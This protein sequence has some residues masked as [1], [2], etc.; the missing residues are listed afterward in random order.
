MLEAGHRSKTQPAPPRII[1]EAL[2]NPDRDPT[3]PWL[4]LLDG[5]QR[6]Q[7]LEAV[8]PGLVVWSSLWTKWPDARIRFD[9]APDSGAGTKLAWTLLVTEPPPDA[10][11]L[12]HLRKR[13]N[14][15]INADLRETFDQ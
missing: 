15:L 11:T 14:K 2:T 8:E 4:F 3:R 10:S 7:V 13:L 9:V 1:F 6:P 5:E 12:S